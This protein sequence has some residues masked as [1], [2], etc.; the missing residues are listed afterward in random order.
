[1]LFK[2]K[3]KIEKSQ[4]KFKKHTSKQKKFLKTRRI[5][6]NFFLLYS[7]VKKN[8]PRIADFP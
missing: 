8:A 1:L 7:A 3:K 2:K 6:K 4:K 5:F